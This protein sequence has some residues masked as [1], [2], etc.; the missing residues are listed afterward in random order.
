LLV[1]AYWT[2]TLRLPARAQVEIIYIFMGNDLQCVFLIPLFGC[3]GIVEEQTS[4]STARPAPGGGP[5]TLT[6]IDNRTGKKYDVKIEE[7]GVIKATDLKKIVAGGDGVGLK[8]Y[9]PGCAPRPFNFL[10]FSLLAFCQ[11]R[12]ISANVPSLEFCFFVRIAIVPG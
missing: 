11:R 7:G 2:D 9:D 5:G 10:P 12:Q 4:A 6:I 3:T 1:P 8:T